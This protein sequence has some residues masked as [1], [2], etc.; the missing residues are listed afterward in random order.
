V[1]PGTL[2]VVATPIG[3]LEDITYR[4]VRILG[5]V[6][7]IAAEDTRHT[8]VLLE[9]YGI[10]TPTTSCFEHNEVVKADWLV[11]RLLG[12]ENIALVSDAG[13]PGIADPG[14]RLIRLA[15]D[16]QIPVVPIPGASALT[17]ALSVAGL[18]I[19]AFYYAGFC[20]PKSARRRRRFESLSEL[21]D[22]LVFYESPHR[23]VPFL[24]DACAVFGNRNAVVARELTKIHEEFRRGTLE[25]HR[26]HFEAH[27]PR[28]EFT[29]LIAGRSNNGVEK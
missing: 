17:T 1:K 22:T 28:G 2:Y 18:P 13:T 5:E 24:R 29:V 27:P 10:A 19:H 14:Y 26:A 4:A 15:L 7:L 12:G 23:V 3:N 20:S 11:G 6:A 25:E 9:R 16:A 8:R 21:E